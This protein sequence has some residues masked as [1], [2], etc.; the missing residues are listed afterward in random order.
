MDAPTSYSR[1]DQSHE[2]AKSD[3]AI[4]SQSHGATKPRSH[5][6]TGPQND[7]PTDRATDP[8]IRSTIA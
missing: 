3:A 4:D 7:R 8:Q 5:S 2:A 1:A 6:A